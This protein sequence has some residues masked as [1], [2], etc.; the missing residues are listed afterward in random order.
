[1]EEKVYG[2]WTV[3]G[4]IDD[5]SGNGVVWQVVDAAGK[6]AAIKVLKSFDNFAKAEK[7]RRRFLNEINKLNLIK[8]LGID[9]VMPILDYNAEVDPLWFVMPLARKLNP[10]ENR[11]IWGLETSIAVSK[12][13]ADLHGIGMVHRDIKPNNILVLNGKIVVSDFGLALVSDDEPLT[14]TGEG[15]GSFGYM[16]PECVGHSDEPQFKCDVYALSKTV[17]V[18]FTGATAP[19][20]GELRLPNDSLVGRYIDNSAV[21]LGQLDDLLVRSTARDPWERPTA[22]QFLDS[23]RAC[24][25]SQSKPAK[26]KSGSPAIRAQSLFGEAAANNRR[27]RESRQ[28]FQ[29]LANEA[30]SKFFA[31]WDGVREGLGWPPSKSSGGALNRHPSPFDSTEWEI[32]MRNFFTGEIDDN[33]Y[34]I[35]LTFWRM[36]TRGEPR[37]K[38]GATIDIQVNNVEYV[39]ASIELETYASG[40]MVEQVRRE[41]LAFVENEET[42][43]RVIEKLKTLSGR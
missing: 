32:S 38:L 42:Q 34:N 27:D 17:W 43:Y 40:P 10:D 19:P 11:F 23:L 29:S 33:V 16:A 5:S 14:K 25:P 31:A 12:C 2:N 8:Q 35:A 9:G 7:R 22:K 28:L 37:L 26:R 21:E 39:L 30:S 15:V 18:F 20:V 6:Q 4:L 3:R 13:I 41:L 36:R 1:M 24:R